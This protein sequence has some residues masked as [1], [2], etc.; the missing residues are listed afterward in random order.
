MKP[1]RIENQM[2]S[3]RPPASRS[4]TVTVF[5][6]GAVLVVVAAWL[7]YLAAT[8]RFTGPPSCDGEI[9][10]PGDAC[11]S[12]RGGASYDYE[13]GIRT[14]QSF[15]T[16][17]RAAGGIGLGGVGAWLL[18]S[19]ARRTAHVQSVSRGLYAVAA[20]L[21][22]AVAGYLFTVDAVPATVG[23]VGAVAAAVR[24]AVGIGW[25]PLSGVAVYL[26]G[27]SA[28]GVA[29]YLVGQ[30]ATYRPTKL[31]GA[32]WNDP[33]DMLVADIVN[34]QGGWLRL[35]LA[36]AAVVAG[37][38]LITDSAEPLPAF[39]A[40][41]GQPSRP[42]RLAQYVGAALVAA[43]AAAYLSQVDTVPARIALGLAILLAL[44]FA[45]RAVRVAR[46]STARVSG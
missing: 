5:G 15:G 23:A 45:V 2:A 44:A 16:S 9:M 35:A 31:Y 32:G 30:A 8:Y 29:A 28:L 36:V 27:L 19:G 26:S 3:D 25:K 4:V 41:F 11:L 6:I 7:L 38:W 37:W 13:E 22:G 33:V 18:A 43:A 12:F 40:A 46:G 20:V 10:S 39:R 42:M 21:L 17:L 24:M 34:G 1:S 14:Q